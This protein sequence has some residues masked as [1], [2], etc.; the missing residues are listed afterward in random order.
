V[1]VAVPGAPGGPGAHANPGP[2]LSPGHLGI[3]PAEVENPGLS[4]ASRREIAGGKSGVKNGR[5]SSQRT[6]RGKLIDLSEGGA[7]C[8]ISEVSALGPGAIEPGREVELRF[9]L[10]DTILRIVGTVIRSTPANALN[11]KGDLPEDA[12]EVVLTFESREPVAGLIRRFVFHHQALARR[13]A[14]QEAES[15]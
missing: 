11:P 14:A 4:W 12:A 9:G 8:W 7:R 3:E 5:G 13:I 1:I 15:G 10:D 6:A 2:S